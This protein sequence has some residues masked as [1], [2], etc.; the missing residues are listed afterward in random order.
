M[1]PGP[2]KTWAFRAPAEELAGALFA[3]ILHRDFSFCWPIYN[4]ITNYLNQ[5]KEKR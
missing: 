3:P 5:L 4:Y 1:K 2:E